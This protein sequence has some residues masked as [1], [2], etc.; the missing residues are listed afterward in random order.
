MRI[1][2]PKSICVTFFLLLFLTDV[3]FAQEKGFVAL[4]VGEA[5]YKDVLSQDAV[6]AFFLVRP[7]DDW[8]IALG[9]VVFS[10]YMSTSRNSVTTQTNGNRQK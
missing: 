5:D 6:N 4:S 3:I 1:L 8:D 10:S 2:K 9:A 7:F